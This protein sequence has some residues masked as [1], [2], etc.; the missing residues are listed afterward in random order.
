MVKYFKEQW[1]IDR[2][3]EAEE[4][5]DNIED[6]LENN[7][8]IAKELGI[9]EMEGMWNIRSMNQLKKQKAVINFIQEEKLNG[10]GIVETYIKPSKLSKVASIAFGGWE[11]VSNSVHSTNGCRIMIGWDKDKVDVMLVYMTRQ[12]ML[13]VVEIIKLKQKV[14]CSFVYASNSGIEKRSLWNDLRRFKAITS[15]C[16]W[17]LMG[18]FNVTL[19]LEE[20][21][22]GGSK[23]QSD[24]QDFGV[25]VNDIEVEDVNYTGLFYTW[26]KSPSRPET[27]ILKKLDRVMVNSDFI[28]HYGDAHA[29]FLPFLTSDHNPVVLHIPNTLEKKKKSFR[30]SNFV[31]DKEEFLDVVKREWKINLEVEAN[32]DCKVVKEKLSSILQEYNEA[33]IDEEKLLA[34]KAKNFRVCDDKGKWFEGDTVVAEQFVKHFEKFLGNNGDAVHINSL[35]ELFINKLT[36]SEAELMVKDITDEEIKEAIFGI[37]NDKALGPDGFVGFYNLINN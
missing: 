35:D 16:P 12:V 2:N 24:M 3:K 36:K 14:F 11:W 17:I 33:I 7:T 13:V 15:G 25:Y 4:D 26:I 5:N 20:H 27:S 18:D 29:R 34:Q 30:F 32:P 6:V 8:G 22:T 19:K 23:V 28:D 37:G 31:A 10:C 21:S 1:E 9:K